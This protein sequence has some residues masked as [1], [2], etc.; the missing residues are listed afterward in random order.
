[1]GVQETILSQCASSV[2]AQ[3][4]NRVELTGSREAFRYRDRS[5]AWQ[6]YT[7]AQVGEISEAVAGGLLSLGL[8]HEERSAI[9]SSTRIE[10][11][12]ACYG[13]NLAGG[14]VTTIYPNTTHEDVAFILSDSQAK[15]VFAENADQV[16]KVTAHTEL[17]QQVATIVV[18]DGEGDGERV[19]TWDD[20]LQRGRQHLQQ[21]P[22]CVREATDATGP[23]TLATLI[24]TSGTTGR[25]K[26]AEL[27]HQSWTYLSVAVDSVGLVSADDMHFLWLPLSH[28]FG[29][30][31][32]VIQIYVGFTTAVD[33]RLDRIVDNLGEVRPTLMCGAPRIFEKVR[34]AV[35]TGATSRGIRGRI[36]AWSFHQG[37]LSIPYR[38]EGRP[39]PTML[40]LKYAI[41]DRLVFSKLKQRLGGRMRF[42]VSGAAKMSRQ[43]QEWFYAAGLLIIE[44][45]G[46]TETSA[47]TFVDHWARPHL[48]TVGPVTPGVEYR[49]AED[50]ELLVRGPVVMRGYHNAPDLTAE[51]LDPDG[52]FHTGDVGEVDADGCLRITDRKKDLLK[53]SGGKYVA[54]QK[55][56]GAIVA[57]IPYV[58]QAVAV[59]DGQKYI[60][61]LLVLDPDLLRRWG[62]RHGFPGASY[63]ELSQ[64]PRVRASIERFLKRA[65]SKLERWE[66][67][68]T[69]AI[70]DHDLTVADGAVTPNMKVRRRQVV[71]AHREIVDSLFV[72][73]P[74]AADE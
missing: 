4:R 33:G 47:V 69:F 42:M 34:V 63:A 18:F 68:K 22:D 61:A 37:K 17:D 27:T 53:T 1:M 39:M 6:S 51:V 65:N 49:I 20:F 14:A 52:W 57:N 21:H 35:L 11:I 16:A 56:E 3:L 19:L 58:S 23:D 29:N 24:Y 15:V 26:G 50:G 25:P 71:E 43:V 66:T 60:A 13:T 31:L 48:G 7:W 46:M 55:V 73:D 67:V 10:W 72:A 45:Y 2:G 59:G 30:C 8:G 12:L 38:L 44:G 36:A 40:A 28:V 74:G 64:M 32:I 54:P 70:L 9:A 62:D 5:D 41:A